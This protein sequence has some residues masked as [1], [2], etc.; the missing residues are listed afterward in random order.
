MFH[1]LQADVQSTDTDPHFHVKRAL[2][3]YN[4]SEENLPLGFYVVVNEYIEW[5]RYTISNREDSFDWC[6][7]V[8]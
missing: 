8:D 6:P 5:S 1:V 2:M 3:K 7:V 4:L